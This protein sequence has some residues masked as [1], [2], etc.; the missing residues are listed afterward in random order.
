[1]PPAHCS[2]R[3]PFVLFYAVPCLHFFLVSSD[4][5]PVIDFGFVFFGNFPYIEHLYKPQSVQTLNQ[6]IRQYRTR[7]GSFPAA[8]FSPIFFPLLSLSRLLNT[9]LRMTTQRMV[10]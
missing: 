5:I 3:C 8:S 10:G 1:M 2:S 4:I 7:G 9:S 6:S